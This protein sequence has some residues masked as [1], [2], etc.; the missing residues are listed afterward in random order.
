MFRYLSNH[1]RKAVIMKVSRFRQG[2]YIITLHGHSFT[3]EKAD[4]H[5][6][7]WNAK[8]VEINRLETKSGTLELMR[9]WSPEYTQSESQ[10]EFC[11][12]A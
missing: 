8:E 4:R 7:L 2:V 11:W 12:Y 5:W 6:T 1:N 9:H 10:H 3:L